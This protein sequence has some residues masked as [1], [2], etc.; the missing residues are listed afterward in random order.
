MFRP[1]AVTA[2]QEL[3]GGGSGE[4]SWANER[5]RGTSGRR[6]QV[7]THCNSARYRGTT[8]GQSPAVEA[9]LLPPLQHRRQISAS[10]RRSLIGWVPWQTTRSPPRRGANK[11]RRPANGEECNPPPPSSLMAFSYHHLHHS[12]S[13]TPTDALRPHHPRAGLCGNL[14]GCPERMGGFSTTPLV[15][16]GRTIQMVVCA[17]THARPHEPAHVHARAGKAKTGQEKRKT[18]D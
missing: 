14:T 17:H 4:A 18:I 12:P 7:P 13:T 15:A 8:P 9:P 11:R 16:L 5:H 6:K 2:L 1:G 3:T 10:W